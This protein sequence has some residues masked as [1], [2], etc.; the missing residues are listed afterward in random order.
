MTSRKKK[1]LEARRDHRSL[2]ETKL[3]FSLGKKKVGLFG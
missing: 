3:E 1:W 2:M